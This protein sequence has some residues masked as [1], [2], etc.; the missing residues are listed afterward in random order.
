MAEEKQEVSLGISSSWF[1]HLICYFVVVRIGKEQK[2][3]VGV[4]LFKWQ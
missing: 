3:T 1:G 4:Y 2:Y